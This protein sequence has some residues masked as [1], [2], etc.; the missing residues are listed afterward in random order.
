[1]PKIAV[2]NHS[3]VVSDADV[4]SCIAA[5]QIQHDRDF[6]PFWGTSCEL[7]FAISATPDEW[8][9]VIMDDSDQADALG[10]HEEDQANMPI[11]FVFAKT[12]IQDGEKW[13]ATFSHELLE[14]L[15]D[16]YINTVAVGTINGQPACLAYETC[17]AVENDEYDISGVAVSNFVTPRWFDPNGAGQQLDFMKKLNQP[18]TLDSGGYIG[19]F[20]V[21][22]QW[23]QVQGR[24]IPG[25]QKVEKNLS[26]RSRRFNS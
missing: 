22:G 7:I 20:T 4:A 9:V 26:R 13:T 6:A 19:Y 15:G 16:P 18:F 2:I 14:M 3:T 11:G 17:D 24:H 5:C 1:M 8:Q 12:S 23:Q 10:Y 25:H 21:I